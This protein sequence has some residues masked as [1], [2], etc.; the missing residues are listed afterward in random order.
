MS[1]VAKLSFRPGILL[2]SPTEESLSGQL[3]SLFQAVEILRVGIFLRS[4]HAIQRNSTPCRFPGG[5][6]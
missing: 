6:I 3:Y 1:K 2:K 4:T 5:D